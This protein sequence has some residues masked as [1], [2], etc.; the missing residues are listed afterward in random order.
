MDILLLLDTSVLGTTIRMA[1]PLLLACLAGL[2][3]ERAGIFDI[4]L[5]GKML[6]SAFLAAAVAYTS[7]NVWIG[8]LAGIAGSLMLSGIHGLASITFR[9]NQLISGV[10]INFFA[11][12]IT[13]VAAQSWFGQGGRTPQISGA[14]R[15]DPII[16]PGA[17]T[18][19]LPR[20]KNSPL[21]SKSSVGNGPE[22]TRVVYAFTIAITVVKRPGPMPEPVDAPPAVELEDVTNG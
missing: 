20:R 3:S 10:A 22:P 5:E 1:T 9:G 14:A 13:V 19:V 16:W 8:L 17:L 18:L 7:G 4:G 11:S 15:F 2:F 21:S 12:G 6:L